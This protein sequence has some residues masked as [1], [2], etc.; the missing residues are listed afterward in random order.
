MNVGQASGPGEQREVVQQTDPEFV[1]L[2]QVDI[3]NLE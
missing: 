2:F 3:A 1:V